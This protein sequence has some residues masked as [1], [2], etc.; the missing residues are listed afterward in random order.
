MSIFIYCFQIIFVVGILTGISLCIAG[1][2]LRRS[3]RGGDL[4][5]LVYIGMFSIIY[6]FSLRNVS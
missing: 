6:N 1:S 4:S 2:V 3:N 5:V